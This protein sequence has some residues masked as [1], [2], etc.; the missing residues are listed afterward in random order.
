MGC[1]ACRLAVSEQDGSHI[2]DVDT[3]FRGC[4][5][6]RVVDSQRFLVLLDELYL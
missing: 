3:E 6:L 2:V 1:E 5:E 4:L